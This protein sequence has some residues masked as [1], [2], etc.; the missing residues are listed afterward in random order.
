MVTFMSDFI[1]FTAGIRNESMPNDLD[2]TNTMDGG[3]VL[4]SLDGNFAVGSISYLN[5]YEW[6][7]GILKFLEFNLNAI[8][9]CEYYK[10]GEN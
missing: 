10:K 9:S 4:S 8:K 5:V 2:F 7:A 1:D 6:L 3:G